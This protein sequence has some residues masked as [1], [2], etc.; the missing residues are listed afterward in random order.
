MEPG[1]V[2]Y[3]L[4]GNNG[5]LTPIGRPALLQVDLMTM[6]MEHISRWLDDFWLNDDRSLIAW[7]RFNVCPPSRKKAG[8][9]E[10][11]T[12]TRRPT[13][14][15]MW[16][17]TNILGHNSIIPPTNHLKGE[18]REGHSQLTDNVHLRARLNEQVWKMSKTPTSILSAY[19]R[20]FFGGQG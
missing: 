15:T 9:W 4:V 6:M 16:V 3:V 20:V 19:Q 7:R 1:A 17:L 8:R 13:S 5:Q 14:R 12:Q 11:S 2:Q 10:H 18:R